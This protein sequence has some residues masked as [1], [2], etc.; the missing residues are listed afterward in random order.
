MWGSAFK[1]YRLH[2]EHGIRN[3]FGFCAAVID[4]WSCE[5]TLTDER[6]F[7]VFLTDRV[8]FL[9]YSCSYNSCA[10]LLILRSILSWEYAFMYVMKSFRSLN[11]FFIVQN[12]LIKSIAL[13][14]ISDWYSL[15]FNAAGKSVIHIINLIKKV[16]YKTIKSKNEHSNI[17]KFKTRIEFSFNGQGRFRWYLVYL[18]SSVFVFYYVCFDVFALVLVN[19]VPNACVAN[20]FISLRRNHSYHSSL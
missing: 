4:H 11:S 19:F 7:Y 1:K 14:N 13:S 8:L 12:R 17:Y 3:T 5:T 9:K 18:I 15:V 6:K 10:L 16:K 2:N 20:G